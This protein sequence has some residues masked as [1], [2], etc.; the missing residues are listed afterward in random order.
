MKRH[1]IISIC[2]LLQFFISVLIGVCMF[3]NV[4]RI[5]ELKEL[6]MGSEIAFILVF[7]A[8][9]IGALLLLQMI[10]NYNKKLLR[11]MHNSK[12]AKWFK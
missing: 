10:I 7:Y 5:E 11:R 2:Y 3:L 12:F 8:W 6:H 9:G 1:R 4:L